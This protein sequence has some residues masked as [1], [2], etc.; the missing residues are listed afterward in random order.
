[1]PELSVASSTR[2]TPPAKHGRVAW[3]ATA[4]AAA[5]DGTKM[6][7]KADKPLLLVDIDGVISLF[8]FAPDERPPGSFVSVDGIPHYLS[9][10]AGEHLR[11]L[12]LTFD[13]AW[14]SGWEERANEHL[15][16]ALGLH[17]SLPHLTFSAAAG[18]AAARHWKLDAIDAYAGPDRTLAWI[19][20][21]HD[22]CQAWADA[23]RG[24]TLLVT[25]QP[26]TGITAEHVDRLLGWAARV[27]GG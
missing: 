7:G 18:G 17:T 15:P 20:D 3:E 11:T 1:M 21:H 8:G 25:A 16:R 27:A 6:P 5:L 22:G 24:P 4:R 10:T 26:P 13:L 2:L 19:D 12:A 9:A 14:C 23:R